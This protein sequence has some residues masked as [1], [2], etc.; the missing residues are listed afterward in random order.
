MNWAGSAGGGCY[1]QGK[2]R[3]SC[4]VG[5]PITLTYT[6]QVQELE[7]LA[8]Y[9][10]DNVLATLYWP[11]SMLAELNDVKSGRNFATLDQECPHRT[12]DL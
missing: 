9:S 1:Y 7:G 8:I 3:C 6:D 4:V 11:S 10:N 2:G 5:E 12:L